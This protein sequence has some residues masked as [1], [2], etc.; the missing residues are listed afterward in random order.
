MAGE[1]YADVEILGAD[2]HL[3][4][5]SRRVHAGLDAL[6]DLH[7]RIGNAARAGMRPKE[8]E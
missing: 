6:K 2:D 5:R 7:K 4:E 8:Q 3:I 1:I